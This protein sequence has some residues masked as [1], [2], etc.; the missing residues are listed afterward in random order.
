ML[1]MVFLFVQDRGAYLEGEKMGLRRRK[2]KE[3]DR[4]VYILA[5]G[6]KFRL[7][8]SSIIGKRKSIVVQ[9]S[10]V[11]QKEEYINN[12]VICIAALEQSSKYSQNKICSAVL[13][14][15]TQWLRS[16]SDMY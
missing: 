5:E 11:K 13:K 2:L 6:K 9:I 7:R 12:A 1:Q 16:R 4:N 10:C 15:L 3:R 14:F 8:A